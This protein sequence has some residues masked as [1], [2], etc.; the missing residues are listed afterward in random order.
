MEYR[1]ITENYAT[2]KTVMTMKNVHHISYPT[3]KWECIPATHSMV[4]FLW[5]AVFLILP[6][7]SVYFD[8]QLFFY[9]FSYVFKYKYV[10]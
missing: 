5:M 2:K 8:P 9:S 1:I 4:F 7:I 6:N 10:L 3:K